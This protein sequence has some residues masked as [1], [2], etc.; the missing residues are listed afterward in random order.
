MRGSIQ[1]DPLDTL[2]NADPAPPDQLPAANLARLR[3]RVFE[4][5]ALMSNQNRQGRIGTV[6]IAIGGLVLASVLAL[7][8]I[9]LPRGTA[10]ASAGPSPGG[11]LT[12][13]PLATVS[14]PGMASC[15]EPY[16]PQALAHRGIAFDG[17]VTEINGDDVSF[18]VNLA[19]RG[20]TKDSIT[21][22]TTGMTG[23]AITS[24]GG[25][26][27]AIGSRYLVAGEDHFAW[28]CGYTQ[29]YDPTVASLWV[30]T[31]AR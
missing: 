14:G 16:S 28:A 10:P 18:H 21:L 26:M 31:F 7:V 20:V 30:A 17:T 27:L 5:V 29:P 24:A 9:A 11:N 13:G 1:N 2:R 15:V 22:T 3:A 19:Y 4:D 8:V 25:P 23:G 12:P 6:H